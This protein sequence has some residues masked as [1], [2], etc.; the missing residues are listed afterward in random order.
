MAE[1]AAMLFIQPNFIFLSLEEAMAVTA[2]TEVMAA[3]LLRLKSARLPRAML[4]LILV[5]AAMAEKAAC[6]T[7]QLG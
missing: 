2:V 6:L 7:L 1:T 5:K 4:Y 3:M